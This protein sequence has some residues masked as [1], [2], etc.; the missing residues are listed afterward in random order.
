MT[1]V[2]TVQDLSTH[3]FL[4]QGVVRAVDGV[5]LAVP[6]GKTLC[7]VGESGCGKSIMALSIMGMV[8]RPGRI[9]S[10]RV[11]LHRD[12]GDLVLTDLDE[13]SPAMRQVRGDDIAMV[14]QE[15]MTSLSPVHTVGSQIVEAVRLHMELSRAG[16]R[17]HAISM[18]GR[19]GIP[20]P[21]ARFRQYAHELS[22]GLRQRVMVAMAL[23]CRPSLLIADEPTTA[24]DVT[25]QAQILALMRE[26]QS[27]LGMAVLFITHD[28]G[29]VA[30]LADEVAVMYLGQVVEQGPVEDI[31]AAPHHPYTTALMRSIP[32]LGTPRKERLQV[33]TGSVPDPFEKVHGCP[34]HPRCELAVRGRCD[35]GDRPTL[36]PVGERHHSACLLHQNGSREHG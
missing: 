15:P 6:R 27:E 31:F 9:V 32:G 14:F 29:V 36:A 28:L 4:D 20:E 17:E 12:G 1:G 23:C 25:I 18:M 5:D 30:Q 13:D 2:V 34:F 10:G 24:L 26:L 21:A 33:I 22:G 19:V 11:T 8:P 3:F 7:V 35:L 16:A